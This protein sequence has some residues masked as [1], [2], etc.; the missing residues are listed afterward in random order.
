MNAKSIKIVSTNI[1][2]AR[3]VMWNGTP[4]MT[5]IY[6]E[7]VAGITIRKFFVEGD[8]VS[9]LKVHGGEHK[10]VYGYPSEHYEYWRREFPNM[11]MPWGTFGENI[12]TEGLFENDLVIG[13]VYRVGT[14]LLQ[15]TEPRMPCYKLGIKFGRVDIIRRFL[16]SRKSGFY[17]TVL[18]KGTAKPGDLIT[19]EH[20][21]DAGYTILDMV[22]RYAR[23]Q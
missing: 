20:A 21:G 10:A 9:D 15:V 1:G 13:S 11:D 22:N 18:E 17:F 23:K 12:T 5:G 19:L 8:N 2:K 4:I 14:A 7:P 16:E 6:K 3:E